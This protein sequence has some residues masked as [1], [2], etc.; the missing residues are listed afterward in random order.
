MRKTESIHIGSWIRS[1]RPDGSLSRTGPDRTLLQGGLSGRNPLADPLLAYENG[2]ALSQWE[3]GGNSGQWAVGGG[4][5]AV[6]G[7]QWR[8]RLARG[9]SED[10]CPT[11]AGC[12]TGAVGSGNSGQWP[13]GR[14]V[15]CGLWPTACGLVL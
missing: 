2:Q 10:A 13:A 12:L 11:G 6:A 1:Q 5:W 3:D 14:S 8:G 9:L 15:A 4:Q 7:G